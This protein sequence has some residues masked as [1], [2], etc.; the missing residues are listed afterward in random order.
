MPE[1]VPVR[2]VTL[3]LRQKNTKQHEPNVNCRYCKKDFYISASKRRNSKSGL[4]FCGREHKYLAQRI[5]SGIADIWP[6]HYTDGKHINY[7]K[8]ALDNHGQYCHICNY[9]RHPS[10]LQVH[11]IDHDRLNNELSNLLVC[12]PTCHMEQHVVN[13]K[14][15]TK[16]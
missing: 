11:H 6:D 14:F 3:V 1:F 10:V 15:N 4:Y 2:V 12:C 13:G 16:H 7:R 8:F 5:R 9:N